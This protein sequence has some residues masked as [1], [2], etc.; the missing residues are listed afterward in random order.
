MIWQTQNRNKIRLDNLCVAKQFFSKT[1]SWDPLLLK[2]PSDQFLHFRILQSHFIKT[3]FLHI[4]RK[5]HQIQ[6]HIHFESE[7]TFA[8]V[9]RSSYKVQECLAFIIKWR[10]KLSPGDAKHFNLILKHDWETRLSKKFII[11]TNRVIQ[12]SGTILK[13]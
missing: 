9:H 3:S 1:L 8:R 6:K 10:I 5:H 13:C 4:P 7:L 2:H 11:R 12:V